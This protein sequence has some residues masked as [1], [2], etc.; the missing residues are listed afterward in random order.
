M[1]REE[2]GGNMVEGRSVELMMTKLAALC[3]GLILFSACGAEPDRS[4]TEPGDGERK[5]RGTGMVLQKDE[6]HPPE[7]CL[8]VV[9]QSYPPQCSG[10]PIVD[11]DWN[12]VPDEESAGGTTWGT[13]EVVGF[14][15]GKTFTAV[16][17]GPSPESESEDDDDP[18]ESAC[19]EPP[20]GWETPD[21]ERSSESDWERA[22]RM[23]EHEPDSAGAWIDQIG[24][25]TEFSDNPVVLNLAFTGDIDEHEVAI[26]EVWGGALCIVEYEHTHDRLSEIQREL[27]DD[28]PEDFG[29]D[30]L[31]SDLDITRNVVL[32]GV[33]VIDPDTLEQIEERYGEGTV[34][35]TPELEPVQSP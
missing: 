12:D 21:P 7:L 24:K 27:S 19:S 23:A 10:P 2:P 15:D 20:G 33:V 9:M 4:A 29:L 18:I 31:Y 32:I 17:A 5:Y 6:D 30:L 22:I 35:V 3:L 25:V 1:L 28:G 8:G 26:R 11:W 16:D 13:Y 34:E 14:Y